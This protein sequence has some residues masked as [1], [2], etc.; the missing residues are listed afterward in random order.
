LADTDC[1][2]SSIERQE[3]SDAKTG[4]EEDSRI[5]SKASHEDDRELSVSVVPD[6]PDGAEV[7]EVK[8]AKEDRPGSQPESAGTS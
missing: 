7:K 1:D 6:I 5:F 2:P 4:G 3:Q 8:S